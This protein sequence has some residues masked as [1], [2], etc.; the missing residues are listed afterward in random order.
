MN[1]EMI[2]YVEE[3]PDTFIT[4]NTGDKMVVTESIDE[5]IDRTIQYQQRKYMLPQLVPSS[6]K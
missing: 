5:V 3:N 2:R 4:L 6:S 1:A